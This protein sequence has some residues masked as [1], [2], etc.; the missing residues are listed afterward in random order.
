MFLPLQLNLQAPRLYAVIA[1]AAGW[2]DPVA[3]QVLAGLDGNNAPAA[4]FGNAASP[5]ATTT[6][7]WPSIAAGLSS[8]VSYR[9]AVVWSN[10]AE[11][12]NVAVS[13]PFLTLGG[14]NQGSAA[15][16]LGPLL[17]AAAA[18]AAVSGASS[19]TLASAASQ[20]AGAVAVAATSAVTL[21]A[22]LSEA[23]GSA[24]SGVAGSA[25]ATLRATLS[26]ASGS[27][28]VGGSGSVAAGLSMALSTASG[29]VA[30]AGLAAGELR[31]F[32]ASAAA[33]VSLAGSASATLGLVRATGAGAVAVVGTS[34]VTLRPLAQAA[35]GAVVGG[36]PI[37]ASGSAQLSDV[38]SAAYG[39]VF[40]PI[41]PYLSQPNTPSSWSYKQTATLWRLVAQ[42]AWA[43]QKTHQLA[44][45]FL[46]DHA[47]DERRAATARGDEFVAKLMVF[48]SL[49][50]IKQGDMIAVGISNEPDPYKAGAQE[51]TAVNSWADTFEAEGAQDFKLT[52]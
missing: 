16:T 27:V 3:L 25:A 43:G 47:K 11:Q 2:A 21:R 48:T 15:A 22:V 6:F 37:T 20:G 17:Q 5:T 24:I 36:P 29:A 41:P 39:V 38:L 35:T 32:G 19:A 7:D 23:N 52:T 50:G 10:G 46:C 8:S 31:N 1:P 18:A 14:A 4:W 33:S 42:D 45:L 49:P 12:S 30:V 9:L 44:G 40:V 26:A 51:V 13:D 28:A 34:L